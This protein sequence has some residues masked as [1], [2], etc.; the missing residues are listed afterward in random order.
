MLMNIVF[1][2]LILQACIGFINGLQMWD[3]YGNQAVTVSNQWTNV[4]ITQ[5]QDIQGAGGFLQ[6]AIAVGTIMFDMMFSAIKMFFSI[7]IS[8]VTIFPMISSFFPW[9]LA[10]PPTIAFLV[11][12]QIGLWFLY[13]Q[14]MMKVFAK[15]GLDVVD[16]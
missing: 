1:Y 4:D 9:M 15:P 14:F 11:L 8:L 10:S 16:L 3:D 7:L 2:L 12:L 13:A 6:Q 5:I